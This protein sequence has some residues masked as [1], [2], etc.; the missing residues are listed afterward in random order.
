MICR[1]HAPF[2][3]LSLCAGVFV[4]PSQFFMVLVSQI[5][6]YTWQIVA[7]LLMCVLVGLGASL[8]FRAD[9]RADIR[10]GDAL[11]AQGRY[12]EAWQLY[13]ALASKTGSSLAL[14]RL[15]MLQTIRGESVGAN[16]TLAQ[17]L[18]AGL[19]G[20]DHDLL[21]LYQGQAAL[22]NGQPSEA[23]G[24]WRMVGETSALYPYRQALEAEAL[25]QAGEYALAE[26]SY[27]A[28]LASNLPLIWQRRIGVRVA[29]LRATSDAEG[30]QTALNQLP[31][32]S[33]TL[34]DPTL[35][36]PLLPPESPTPQRLAAALAAPAT[37][38]AIQ[39]GQLYLDA[40]LYGLAEAQFAVVPSESASAQS[41]RA[42]AA[43]ARLRTG[44]RKA[45]IAQLKALV[46]SDPQNPRARALLAL[47][48][49]AETNPLQAQAQLATV[50]ALAPRS[51]DTHL[52]WG[53]WYAAN[54]DYIAAANEYRR[55]LAEA[56]LDQ[57]ATYLLALAHFHLDTTVNACAG[58]RPA[59]EE[60]ARLTDS[61]AAWVALAQASLACED[62]AAASAAAASAL[63]R[64]PASAEAAFYH[65]RALAMLGQRGAARQ[66]LI[67]AADLAPA[68]DWRVKAENQLMAFRL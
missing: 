10:R 17:A 61:A 42:Y 43:Y 46:E 52:A 64:D 54:S 31:P 56:P 19:R 47:A 24:L 33:A 26:A 55:A 59:A 12:F 32:P 65:G 25:L 11:F 44:D 48:Y 21:R 57:R 45:G 53:Q 23:F 9:I 41:A 38:R 68:S 18:N 29:A 20:R 49:L 34:P 7:S 13:G 2:L 37:E 27:R 5:R 66:A 63:E 35:L 30:A 1:L 39:L 3:S 8:V 60:A 67:A 50:R 14:A 58:A 6:R 28:A 62:Y 15:G 22:L 51:P 16:R 4:N 36:M 40:G